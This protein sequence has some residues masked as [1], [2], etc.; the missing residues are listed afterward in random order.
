MNGEGQGLPGSSPPPMDLGLRGA[1]SDSLAHQGNPPQGDGGLAYNNKGGGLPSVFSRPVDLEKGLQPSKGPGVLGKQ[2][3][4]SSSSLGGDFLGGQKNVLLVG[5]GT[6]IVL[7]GAALV[8]V[9]RKRLQEEQV[10]QV[11]RDTHAS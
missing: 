11:F 1:G 9:R 8:I 4:K 6:A 3:K 10:A 7:L 2:N 5:V